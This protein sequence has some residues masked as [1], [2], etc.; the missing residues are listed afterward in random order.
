M[1]AKRCFWVLVLALLPALALATGGV[2]QTMGQVEG[3]WGSI[4]RLVTQ[5]GVAAV[6]IGALCAFL[7]PQRVK[8]DFPVRWDR[9]KRALM[10]RLTSFGCGFF[11]TVLFW[12]M[13]WPWETMT[14]MEIYGV[15][16]SG[17]V[18]S[19]LV[20]AAAPFTYTIVMNRLYKKGWLD[21]KRWSGEAHAEVKAKE[22][23]T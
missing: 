20:G 14:G 21:E 22:G 5:P 23:E 18:V 9:E 6:A 16:A 17:L 3:A 7:I 11:G 2:Q 1:T 4:V 12:P 19:I 10:T 8:M 13:F 15:M